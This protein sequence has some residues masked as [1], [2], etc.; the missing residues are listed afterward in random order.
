MLLEFKGRTHNG[1]IGLPAGHAGEPK[2]ALHAVGQFLPVHPLQR[3]LV[4]EQIEVGGRTA[5]HQV[6]DALSP[7]PV[8]RL[9]EDA[10]A[11]ARHQRV[12]EAAKGECAYT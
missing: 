2:I 6:D 11:V 1:K 8:V 10:A 4:I 9:P 3:G 7:G 12:D 5:L